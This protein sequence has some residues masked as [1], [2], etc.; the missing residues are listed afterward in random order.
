MQIF[1]FAIKLENYAGTITITGLPIQGKHQR[2][3]ISKYDAAS[4]W[5]SKDSFQC[6]AV[7][8]FHIIEISTLIKQM[9][10]HWRHAPALLPDQPGNV[11]Y[12]D[13]LGK[14]VYRLN[15]T[16]EIPKFTENIE[17]TSQALR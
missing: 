4:R 11:L 5:A 16:T 14:H 15:F 7:F 2:L 1:A 3:N 13:R 6:A 9:Q 8:D 10:S 17:I 12:M